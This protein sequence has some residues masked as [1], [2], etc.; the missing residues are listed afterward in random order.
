MEKGSISEGLRSS[1]TYEM[2]GAM[3]REKVPGN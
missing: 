1:R 3:V 2:S